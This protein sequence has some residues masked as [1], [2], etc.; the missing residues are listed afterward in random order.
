MDSALEIVLGI[1]PLL[2]ALLV[3]Y[4]IGSTIEAHHYRRLRLR[5]KRAR[6]FPVLTLQNLPDDWN[7]TDSQLVT[8]NVVISVDYF[9]RFLASLRMF[10]GGRIQSYE[11]LM[12]R[13]RREALIRLK[14]VTAE[15][16]F[17]ALLNV[18]LETSRMASGRGG[19]GVAGI[20]VL[21]YATALR[22][23][24]PPA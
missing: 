17:H 12:D 2:L 21:A 19:S 23:R 3:T 18:R 15:R 1:G 4:L 14:V 24:Q 6:Q 11:T 20:E 9:K 10:F 13:A 16:G 7:V 22:L 5:E 8:G